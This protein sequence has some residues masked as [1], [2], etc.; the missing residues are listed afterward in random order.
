MASALDRPEVA[1][2]LA[3]SPY[4]EVGVDTRLG[5]HVTPAAFA[6]ASGRL[7][8]VSSRRTVRVR[9]VRRTGHAAALVRQDERAVVVSG[10]AQ[11]L[12]VWRRDEALALLAGSLPAARAAAAYTVRNAGTVLAGFL[13]DLLMGAGD[14]TVYDRVL[15]AI[16]ADRGMLLD[17][18]DLLATWGRWGTGG[19]ARSGRRGSA[20]Q[21]APRQG[22]AP[23][24][25]DDLLRNLPP[26]VAATL[27]DPRPASLGWSTPSGCVVLPAT[28]TATPG[29]VTVA[30][31]A[32]D[33]AGGPRAQPEGACVTVHDSPGLR[34][35]TFHGAVLRGEGR[36]ARHG[37]ERSTVAVA[38]ERISWWSGFESGTSRGAAA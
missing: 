27:D 14:P 3:A 10:R 36:V 21:R 29:R 9:S 31:A 16:D 23:P 12:S 15:V 13:A 4:A 38:A 19:R 26:R 20:G 7:W 8:V 28:G 25:L 24:S 30:S 32:L 11:V 35:S 6:A 17:G 1:A 37:A 22:A 2:L 34:P 5:P 33:H 18:P